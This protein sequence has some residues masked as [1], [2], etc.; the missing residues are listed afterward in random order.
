LLAAFFLVG[1]GLPVHI[2]NL[3]LGTQHFF[4]FAMAIDAPGH[5]QRIGLEDQRHLID[6]PVAGGTANT[7]IDMNA[8]IEIDEISEAVHFHP[9]DGLIGAVAHAHRLEISDVIE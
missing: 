9:L 8:V 2:E 5:Q 1:R 6:L 7:L 3:I 4:W